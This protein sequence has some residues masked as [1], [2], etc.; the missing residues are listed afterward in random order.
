MYIYIY[1]IYL[2]IYI[3]KERNVLAFFPVLYKRTSLRSFLFF[4]KEWDILSC[5]F[6]KTGKEC[7]VLL[8]LISRQKLKKRTE[9]SLK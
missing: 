6:E 4:T 8:S 5:S 1:Y 2:Y 3:E 9:S 7:S